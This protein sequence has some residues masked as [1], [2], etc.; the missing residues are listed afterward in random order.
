MKLAFHKFGEGKPLIVLHGLYGSSDNWFTIGKRLSE[1]FKVYLVDQRNHGNSPHHPEHS[2]EAMR[3]DLYEFINRHHLRQV[4]LMGHSMGGKTA[5]LFA[6]KYQELVTQ[7]IVI[8]ISP[9]DYKNS[10]HMHQS[11]IHNKIIS[12]LQLLEPGSIRD[13]READHLLQNSIPQEKVR[14]FLLKNLKQ[15]KNG[16][17]QWKLNVEALAQNMRNLSAGIVAPDQVPYITSNVLSLFIKSEF[18]NYIMEDD[19][20]IIYRIFPSSRIIQIPG[21]GHWLHAE[22]PEFFMKAVFDFI[23]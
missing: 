9:V 2:Y 16:T 6:L 18:S 13:R 11:A 7:L 19:E 14:Q 22:Q 3:D 1:H 4:I 15:N 12:A 5:M 23:G 10:T 20:E 8:D 17:Y 21:T